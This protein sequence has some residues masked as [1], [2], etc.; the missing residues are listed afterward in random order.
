MTI[1]NLSLCKFVTRV[2]DVSGMSSLTELLMM[3]CTNLI[4]I[5]D[6]VGLL[7]KLKTLSAYGCRN[8]RTFPQ[9]INLPS[10]KYLELSGCLSLEKF[11]EILGEMKCLYDLDWKDTNLQVPFSLHNLIALEWIAVRRSRL[12]LSNGIN[13]V[14]LPKQVSSV[15]MITL[16]ECHISDELL[17]TLCLS[18]FANVKIFKFKS[19]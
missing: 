8:L 5:H 15:V 11:P 13:N 4:E 16:Q 3:F 14:M 2:P 19:L 7:K 12:K 1:L 10:L 17:P 6:S 18:W 9:G